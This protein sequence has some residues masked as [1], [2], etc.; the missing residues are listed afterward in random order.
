M[1]ALGCLVKDVCSHIGRPFLRVR[2]VL[3]CG[4][5]ETLRMSLALYRRPSVIGP[6]CK[7]VI[8]PNARRTPLNLLSTDAARRPPRP[9]TGTSVRAFDVPAL[10]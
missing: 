2:T 7:G 1:S 4:R 6:V 5:R 3:Q 9:R 10:D 8:E